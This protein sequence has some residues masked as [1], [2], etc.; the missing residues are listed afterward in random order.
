MKTKT[1]IFEQNAIYFQKVI[2][3]TVLKVCEKQ[4]SSF[5]T[6]GKLKITLDNFYSYI[7]IHLNIVLNR[8]KLYKCNVYYV[9][10]QNSL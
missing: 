6:Y 7:F 4:T 8:I 5:S 2:F 9:K 3:T 1:E 10:I